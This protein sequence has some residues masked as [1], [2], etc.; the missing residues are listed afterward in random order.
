MSI[1]SNCSASPYLNPFS[2]VHDQKITVEEQREGTC[3]LGFFS[4]K[5]CATYHS[6]GVVIHKPPFGGFWGGLGMSDVKN[7]YELGES[8]LPVSDEFEY[9]D[10]SDL[11]SEA[12]IYYPGDFLTDDTGILYNFT[13][14]N[15]KIVIENGVITK[16]VKVY[17]P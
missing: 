14:N 7:Y 13:P 3:F 9:V 5:D 8:T 11:D 10:E 15:T 17:T 16:M 1:L 2:T 12:E 6:N 4:A